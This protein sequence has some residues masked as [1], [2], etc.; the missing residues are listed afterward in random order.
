MLR[1]DGIIKDFKPRRWGPSV[2]VLDGVDLALGPGEV[3]GLVGPS[4]SGKTTLARIA[5]GLIPP[6]SGRVLL[7]DDD[8]TGLGGSARRAYRRRVQLI[9]QNPQLSLDPRQTIFE[10]VAEPLKAH[11]L[12]RSDQEMVERVRSLTEECGLTEDLLSR[13]PHQISGG[14]A[15]RAVLARAL[16]LEPCVLIGDEL[17]SM[18]DVSVQAQ[19]LKILDRRRRECGLTVCLISHDLDL[20]RAFC[21]RAGILSGGRIVAEGDPMSLFPH[22]EHPPSQ[23]PLETAPCSD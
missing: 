11:G 23:P 8:V 1:L 9:F 14:Q 20:V 5:M 16:G 2:R 7:S 12:V 6:S 21:P 10:S 13:R 17:T 19:V 3:Y 4:G 15:Q 18:L 22:Q